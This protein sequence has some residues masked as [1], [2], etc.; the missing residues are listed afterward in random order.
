V[1]VSAPT[2]PKKQALM[3]SGALRKALRAAGHHLSPVVQ[4]GKEGLTPGVLAQL[5]EA[6]LAHELVKL[7]VGTESPEDRFEMAARLAALPDTFLASVLGRTLLVYRKHPERPRFE[8]G[9]RELTLPDPEILRK[10]RR[11][12]TRRPAR[13]TAQGPE[14]A[15]ERATPRSAAREE[16]RRSPARRS[17]RPGGRPA[18]PGGR[19]DDRTGQRPERSGRPERAWTDRRPGE[20]TERPTRRPGERPERPGQRFDR[21]G[22][23]PDKRPGQRFDRMGQRPDRRPGAG[24][25]AKPGR[26]PRKRPG[27]RPSR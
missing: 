3:P 15:P 19:P 26:G 25:A 1:T 2:N 12:V 7:K 17:D 16:A 6:L 27:R 13:P 24:P 8:A 23:R 10:A 18:R 21:T 4:A 20:R 9:P 11:N 5:D 22:A 14:R